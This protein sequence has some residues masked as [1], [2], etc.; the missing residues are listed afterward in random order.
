MLAHVARS[1][2][3]VAKHLWAVR[4]R[5][6]RACC[7]EGRDVVA[8]AWAEGLSGGYEKLTTSHEVKPR[9]PNTC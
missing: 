2:N 4:Q 7:S 1:D 6:L 5:A 3:T 9:S 8:G